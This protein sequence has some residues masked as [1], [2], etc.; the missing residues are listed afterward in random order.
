M[1]NDPVPALTAIAALGLDSQ[2]SALIRGALASGFLGRC[3]SPLSV[4]ALSTVTGLD[5]GR[6]AGLCTVLR[7]LGV[8]DEGEPGE[9]VLSSLYAQL[10]DN[11]VD[12]LATGGLQG[13]AV[14]GRILESLF[15]P[16]G[17]VDYQDLDDADRAAVAASVAVD[18]F[19][20]LARQAMGAMVRLVPVWQEQ[21]DAG[22][23][24][25]ELGCGLAGAL[26]TW[27]QIYPRLIVVGVD[28]A[29]D[30]VDSARKRA[31]LLGVADRATFVTGDA[32]LYDDPQ[33]FDTAL[34]SQFFFPRATREATL[35]NAFA[36]LRPGGLLVAPVLPREQFALNSLVVE[37][38]DVPALTAEQLAAEFESAGFRGTTVVPSP[39][40]TVVVARRP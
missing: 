29:G 33:P 4:E 9:Y 23:R 22:G 17:A 24:F 32:T 1:T 30:L 37:A 20:P 8:L 27:L 25:L 18:P 34:W 3:R 2:R 6:V 40:T 38:W 35:A 36:R 19:S 16:L 39:A 15:T 12:V 10:F 28:V 31:E 11:G 5:A 26:L 7:E 14:R 21:F 13:A